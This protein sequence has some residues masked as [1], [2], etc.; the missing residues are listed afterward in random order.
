MKTRPASPKTVPKAV[1]KSATKT[2]KKPETVPYHRKP[3]GLSHEA[4]QKAL[5]QQFV[6]E[7]AFEIVRLAGTHPIFGDYSV[8][9]PVS[10]R[11][12]KVAFRDGGNG[13]NYCECLDF[14]TNRLGTCKHIE[15]VLKTVSGKRGAKK[16]LREGYV[17]PYT[18]VYLHY[19]DTRRVRIRIGMENAHEFARLAHEYFDADLVLKEEAGNRF[20]TFLGSAAAIDEGFRCYD[21]ALAFILAKRETDRRR[22]LIRSKYAELDSTAGLLKTRLYPYQRNG[23]LFAA[24]AGRS[25]IADEMGL[26]K[27]IQAIG[28]AELLKR[29]AGIERVL[30]VCPTSLKYQWRSEIM[31]FTDSAI[32]VIE[33]QA[34]ARGKQYRE[35]AFFKIVSYHTVAHDL[36]AIARMAPDLVILDEAQRIKNWKTRIART[37]KRIESPF[38]LVLTGTPLEN[39]LEELYS[40]VSFIN[41]WKLG[42]FWKFLSEHQVKDGTGKVTGYQGL[43]EI[44]ERLSDITLRRRKKEVLADL[45]ERIDK[46]IFVPMTAQQ[47]SMHDEFSDNAARLIKKWKHKGFLTEQERQRLLILLNEMR[48]VCDSTYILDQDAEHRHDVK[49]G[50]LMSILE[51]SLADP[52]QKVVVFSQWE[53]MTRLVAKELDERGIGYRN[54]HGGVPSVQRQEL[55]DSFNTLPEC[56]VF[57]STDAGSTGL[58]LQSAS[59]LVNLD[60]PWNP[61]V[62]EQRIGRIHRIGQKKNV[63]I[64]NFVSIDTIES[65]MLDLIGFKSGL[66]RGILDSGEDSI[67]MGDDKHRRFMNAVQEIV[68]ESETER[69]PSTAVESADEQREAEELAGRIG[70]AGDEDIA[71]EA[72]GAG[73]AAATAAAEP[74]E[75]VARGVSFLSD[76]SR[77]LSAPGGAEAFVAALSE[78]DPATGKTYLKIPVESTAAAAGAISMLAGLF[79]TLGAGGRPE[80]GDKS[81]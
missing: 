29:E 65:R 73:T 40:I 50:E 17:P 43:R 62:L 30:V 70:A 14:R 3:E 38:A 26:G 2:A 72:K 56:R 75:L 51:E 46:R 39:N 20:E 57:I 27:T 25:L 63:T 44:G 42:P 32:R 13:L 11:S 18:S 15:A 35:D 22:E 76:L 81:Q 48:M 16:A 47:R 19:G 53:R 1:P 34:Q 45:P 31:K 5:R 6:P 58:N 71:V 59:I 60:L 55:F 23:I 64:L 10:G 37:V 54:L 9:N 33:G 36:D 52:E 12:Y 68:V 78:T 67:F 61:A 4:W 41:P 69:A 21:D 74:G 24:A 80:K 7:Q 66:A 8:H 77:S 28:A 79:S 49:I